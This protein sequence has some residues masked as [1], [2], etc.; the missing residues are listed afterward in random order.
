VLEV[1][2]N[3]GIAVGTDGVG[4]KLLVAE[5][6]GRLD[7]V[8]IDCVA[9]NVNDVVCVG[10]EP[11]AVLDYLAVE[12]PEPAAMQA[13]AEGLKR[14]AE[15]AGVEIPGGEVAVL[16]EIIRGHPSP[17]GF[18]LTAACFG[19]VALDA[20]VS[21]AACAPGDALI[22]LPS[23]GLHSNGFSL[24]RRALADIALDERPAALGGAT[25]ADVLLEPTVIYVRAVL[26]LLRS[27]M[28]VHGLAHITGG[29]LQNLTRLSGRVGFEVS[30]PLPVPPIFGLVQERGGVADAEMWDVFNM[31]CGFCAVVPAAAADEAVALLAGHHPGTRRIGTITDRAGQAYTSSSPLD[32]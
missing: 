9:M 2:P 1:A 27:G 30:D 5:A 23:S 8:G 24:A 17:H 19:T 6:T 4:S 31:G 11:I 22:G 14:G 7:T 28:P 21:G 16:P 25:L 18:D 15:L 3:L 26:E 20:I 13:I 12:Q 29:G 10:A 32:G